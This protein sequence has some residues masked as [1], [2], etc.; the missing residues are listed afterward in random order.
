MPRAAAGS[1]SPALTQRVLWPR[2]S[3]A[4]MPM[5]QRMPVAEWCSFPNRASRP[6]PALYNKAAASG[7]H[8]WHGL[9]RRIAVGRRPACPEQQHWPPSH[10]PIVAQ[11]H[12]VPPTCRPRRGGHGNAKCRGQIG[13]ERQ[14]ARIRRLCTDRKA[15]RAKRAWASRSQVVHL[16]KRLSYGDAGPHCATGY[17]GVF[18]EATFKLGEFMYER[19]ISCKW[20]V[21]G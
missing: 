2:H 17:L 12:A 19:A 18:G 8:W 3:K 6:W 14:P 13:D 7:I 16:N 1:T 20:F 10:A 21:A 5:T 15:L 9:G 11:P 4:A